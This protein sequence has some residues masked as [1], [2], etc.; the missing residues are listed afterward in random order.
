[1]PRDLT[2]LAA[3]NSGRLRAEAAA[4]RTASGDTGDTERFGQTAE[5]SVLGT[6]VKPHKWELFDRLGEVVCARR[7][8]Q[9]NPA[10]DPAVPAEDTYANE[11]G[12]H[13]PMRTAFEDHWTGGRDFVYFALL[14]DGLAPPDYGD[15]TLVV[16]PAEC[17]LSA[18]AC[19]PGN[20]AER[21]AAS[22]TLDMARCESEAAAW[23]DR[24]AL[25]ATKR[26]TDPLPAEVDWPTL[27]C[28]AADFSE[29]V[30]GGGIPRSAIVEVRVA[31]SHIELWEELQ[32]RHLG[33]ETL[34]PEEEQ[35]VEMLAVL[36]RW[37]DSGVAIVRM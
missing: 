36:D 11:Q 20:T 5:I 27:V 37:S 12:R 29:G 26:G 24:G 28:R 33:G 3:L 8:S 22:G 1:M 2:A 15:Y 17:T 4:L 19:F 18:L 6:A 31:T 34:Q 30:A 9:E 13:Y 7:I 14:L 25:L 35:L 32:L 21:Y 23:A 16:D 10:R